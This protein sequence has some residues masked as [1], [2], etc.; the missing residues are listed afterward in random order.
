MADLHRRRPPVFDCRL[1]ATM[2]ALGGE[3]QDQL[4]PFRDIL[5]PTA[6][7]EVA[8][9]ALE[10]L[11]GR[12]DLLDPR[13]HDDRVRAGPG[14]LL[15]DD[16]FYLPDGARILD[17]LEFDDRLRAGDVLADVALLAMDVEA[18][19]ESQA[20]AWFLD[21]PVLRRTPSLSWCVRCRH[22]TAHRRYHGTPGPRPLQQ[23][24][25]AAPKRWA[26]TAG[27]GRCPQPGVPGP[28]ACRHWPAE[29][30]LRTSAWTGGRRPS[31]DDGGR[32]G[33]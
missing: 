3:G 20:A 5:S 27:G 11:A 1:A 9:L 16:I 18:L 22:P 26:R 25:R 7:P 21:R 2:R 17:C 24:A 12:E 23:H 8:A 15:A 33:G 6:V 14:H 10:Y 32:R 19:G 28:W 13:E 31:G 4:R 30:V 29:H